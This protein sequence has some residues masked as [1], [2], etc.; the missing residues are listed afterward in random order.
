M[1]NVSKAPGGG[2]TTCPWLVIIPRRYSATGRRV[3]RRFATKS[4]ATAFAEQT[5]QH[6]RTAGEGALIGSRINPADASAAAALLEG[7]GL[8]LTAAVRTLLTLMPHVAARMSA[9]TV[10]G[11]AGEEPAATPEPQP[12]PPSP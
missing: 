1:I 4:R 6:L 2:H 12:P 10:G 5:R 8:S 9:P 11:G 7:T 3:Y